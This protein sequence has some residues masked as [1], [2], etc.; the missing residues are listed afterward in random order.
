MQKYL[1][2]A[3][4]SPTLKLSKRKKCFLHVKGNVFGRFIKK[5]IILTKKRKEGNWFLAGLSAI[6]LAKSVL[7]LKY[8]KISVL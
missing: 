3:L 7:H 8:E 6:Y 2:L 1:T 5:K 4:C